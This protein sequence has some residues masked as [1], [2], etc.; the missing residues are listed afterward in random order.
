MSASVSPPTAAPAGAPSAP[1]PNPTGELQNGAGF[2]A[3]PS[4]PTSA[5]ASPST[6]PGPH[7]VPADHSLAITGRPANGLNTSL[8]STPIV[9]HSKS[10]P[11]Q[12]VSDIP[13]TGPSA[14]SIA[15]PSHAHNKSNAITISGASHSP[16]LPS[17]PANP[18]HVLPNRSGTDPQGWQRQTTSSTPIQASVINSAR[19]TG[20]SSP[21]PRIS[22]GF[23]SPKSEA[24]QTNQKFLDDCDRL[25]FGI[26]QALPEAVRRSVRDNW[27]ACLL[28]SPFHQAFVV[29]SALS[30]I[31]LH[32]LP[33]FPH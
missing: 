5:S 29:S 30:L 18:N 11:A 32:I 33:R 8:T 1:R 12:I 4:M 17:T 6:T 3:T 26:Q 22:V 15:Q 27:E 14:N 7:P 2:G 28:G 31:L 20:N 23:P 13:G 16:A 19:S 24:M 10:P 21:A 25:K 9:R